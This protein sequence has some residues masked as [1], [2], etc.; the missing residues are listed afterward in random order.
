MTSLAKGQGNALA[1]AWCLSDYSCIGGKEDCGAFL[2]ILVGRQNS[3]MHCRPAEDLNLGL[4]FSFPKSANL[5]GCVGALKLNFIGCCR[6][7]HSTSIFILSHL[8]LWG[9]G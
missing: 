7:R 1:G 2:L 4:H 8:S 5:K 6:I 3:F 9:S